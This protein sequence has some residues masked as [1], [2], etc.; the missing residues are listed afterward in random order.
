MPYRAHKIKYADTF[1]AKKCEELLQC[2]SSS[3]LFVKN[4]TIFV[5]NTFEI[6]VS[7]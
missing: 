6:I 2:K 1:L 3:Y 4:D 7:P 5:N